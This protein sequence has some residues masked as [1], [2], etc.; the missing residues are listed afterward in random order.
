VI[1]ERYYIIILLILLTCFLPGALNPEIQVGY[2][3][4]SLV[5]GILS[6]TA[7]ISLTYTVV[8]GNLKRSRI[9]TI[10]YLFIL[11]G[12]LS[13]FVNGLFFSQGYISMGAGALL[14]TITPLLWVV[15]VCNLKMGLNREISILYYIYIGITLSALVAYL[16]VNYEE[17]FIRKFALPRQ[18]IQRGVSKVSVST[19]GP[20]AVPLGLY[21]VHSSKSII[22]YA[23]NVLMVGVLVLGIVST[24]TRSAFIATIIG[25]AGYLYVLYRNN[26]KAQYPV[27]IVVLLTVIATTY[28][29]AYN[30]A[31]FKRI[32]DLSTYTLAGLGLRLQSWSI[33]TKEF[34]ESPLFG[35][36]MA[37][38]YQRG[39]D[40][41][42]IADISYPRARILI[43]G[44]MSLYEPHNTY[45][46]ILA[47]LGILG[48]GALAYLFVAPFKKYSQYVS[49]K[50][51]EISLLILSLLWGISSLLVTLFLN[52]RI[53]RQTIRTDFI[54]MLLLGV[55][56]SITHNYNRFE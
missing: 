14:Y 18:R 28:Y 38:V 21:F 35:K 8:S 27:S 2:F 6:S 52:T 47:E 37:L 45:I 54:I 51:N 40:M 33:A 9:N 49:K 15:V 22:K 16:S 42:F 12:V 53:V 11:T 32:F 19:L 30:I 7:V 56:I 46:T 44:E 39:Y 48:F 29:A 26:H 31:P 10:S 17:Y 24:G 5:F 55:T 3:N 13:L 50:H 36:G 23:I 25:A 34:L 41:A 43:D 20:L 4:Y 1:K